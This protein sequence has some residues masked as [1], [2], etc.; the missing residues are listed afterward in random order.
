MTAALVFVFTYVALS[1]GRV[2]G[3]RSDRLAAAIIG[4]VLLVAL[5]VLS[6]GDAQASVDGGG[7]AMSEKR[8]RWLHLA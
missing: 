7:G 5:R 8:K 2:P 3:F 4:A 1:V 6:L